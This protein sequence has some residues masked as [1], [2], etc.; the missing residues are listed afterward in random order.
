LLI[1]A[2]GLTFV[3][4]AQMFANASTKYLAGHLLTNAGFGALVLVGVV[5]SPAL[6]A[7][8]RVAAWIGSQSYSIYLWHAAVLGIGGV[9]V[10][11]FARRQLT[12]L[13]TVAWYVPLS[14][15]SGIVAAKLIELPALRLRDRLFPD[16]R[17][18][19]SLANVT[20]SPAPSISVGPATT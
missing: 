9:V 15:V 6:G 3:V 18:E 13:E 16:G 12:F 8:G 2:G 17:R 14:F 19:R 20:P 10:E 7:L 11:H 4:M 5:G 1:A